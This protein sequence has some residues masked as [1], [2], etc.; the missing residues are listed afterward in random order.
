MKKLLSTMMVL[1]MLL[2]L[3]ATVAVAQ[4]DQQ[5]VSI[6]IS[7]WGDTAR[8]EKYNNWC[9]A[10]EAQYPGI[11]I[12][13]EYST[14]T[15]YWQKLPT[16]VAAGNAPDV[17]GMHPQFV[18]D[19][20]GRGVLASLESFVADGV[21]DVSNIAASV[22]D[23][24]TD[25]SGNIIM[26]PMGL[27]VQTLFTNKTICDAL[28]VALPAMDDTWT[29]ADLA[30]TFADFREKAKAAGQ[31]LYFGK[32]IVGYTSFQYLARSNGH[33]LYTEDG[34]LG[35]TVEDVT[36]Y[37]DYWNE[38]RLADLV[39][40][41]SEV[42]QD[43]ALTLEQRLFAQGKIAYEAG[44]VN[45]LYLFEGVRPDDEIVCLPMP[46]GDDGVSGAFME[47]AHWAMSSQ[48][49]EEHQAAA[50]LLI[51]F[52]ENS[53]D[54]WQYMLMDQGVPASSEMAS[55]IAPMLNETNQTAIEFVQIVAQSASGYVYAP[56]GASEINAKFNEYRDYTQF[57]MMTPAE[58]AQ[59]FY[60]ESKAV[61]GK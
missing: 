50:A 7:W 31:D 22:L 1:V 46:V 11:T 49:D 56:A 30:A 3:V 26:L 41:A 43:G 52:L 39:P 32:D 38:L 24:C 57:G 8:H 37:W 15:D 59:A 20:S 54:C 47:G 21:I 29:W 5:D 2:S 18:S 40:E 12:I 25:A 45:Q 60:D 6:R 34:D 13:R 42:T 61:L 44:P 58:A 17:M 48:S 16:Q 36:Q 4:E 53:E 55:Y 19:Y 14:W 27:T 9:D 35:F 33:D 10:F 51:N 28:G 23:G